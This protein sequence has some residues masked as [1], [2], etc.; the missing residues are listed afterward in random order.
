MKHGTA[1]KA[2][3]TA[4]YEKRTMQFKTTPATHHHRAVIPAGAAGAI[5]A[6]KPLIQVGT[7][8]ALAVAA[9]ELCMRYASQCAVPLPP[10]IC[11]GAEPPRSALCPQHLRPG[12]LDGA[13]AYGS[14]SLSQGL[15][16]PHLELWAGSCFAKAGQPFHRGRCHSVAELMASPMS[17]EQAESSYITMVLRVIFQRECAV[18]VHTCLL[19]PLI[20]ASMP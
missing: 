6:M 15:C 10:L 11:L 19:R 1:L 2:N 9:M 4:A 5:T 3:V 14:E 8:A 12:A 16:A 20:I 17:S 13:A 7:G 18:V